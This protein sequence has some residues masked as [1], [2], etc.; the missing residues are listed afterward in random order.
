MKN[1]DNE[2]IKDLNITDIENFNDKRK[3][4]FRGKKTENL[5]KSETK[6]S[7]MSHCIALLKKVK[8]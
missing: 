7:K 5:N 3:E 8:I 4:F 2:N 6:D 1:E